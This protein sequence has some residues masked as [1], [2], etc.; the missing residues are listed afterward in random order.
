M[1]EHPFQSPEARRL[2]V[3]FAIVAYGLKAASLEGW[4]AN[5]LSSGV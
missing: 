2:A 4:T 1:R 3:L 5:R